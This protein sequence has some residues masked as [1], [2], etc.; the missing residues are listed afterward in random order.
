MD[1]YVRLHEEIGTSAAEFRDRIASRWTAMFTVSGITCGFAYT[2]IASKENL[3]DV[4]CEDVFGVLITM[5][6]IFTLGAAL[7][8]EMWI[9]VVALLGPNG[10]KVMLMKF[11]SLVRAPL[12]LSIFGMLMFTL[13]VLP[14]VWAHFTS[15]VF[16]FACAL[17]FVA[18]VAA[19]VMYNMIEAELSAILKHTEQE[20]RIRLDSEI[21]KADYTVLS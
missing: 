19:T 7:L 18:I 10:T 6:F 15:G 8:A 9:G 20:L 14:L 21:E 4:V 12:Q 11:D 5:A 3:G 1:Q 17:W 16:Y 13:S 2:V